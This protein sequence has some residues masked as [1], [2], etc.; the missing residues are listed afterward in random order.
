MGLPMALNLHKSGFAVHGFDLNPEAVAAAKKVGIIPATSIADAVKDVDFVVT[1]LPK[2]DHVE[3]ALTM[4]G[5]IFKSA[6]KGTVICDTSTISPMASKKFHA[7]SKE[8]GLLFCDTPMSGGI[9]GAH[10]KTLS[11]MVGCSDDKEFE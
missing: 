10:N 7:E 4:E 8:H 1:A 11:F 6:K 5:G 2:T 3:K 9:M